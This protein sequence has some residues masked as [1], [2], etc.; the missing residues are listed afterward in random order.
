MSFNFDDMSDRANSYLDTMR[1]QAGEIIAKAQREGEAIRRQAEEEGRQAAIRA[2]EKVMEEKVGKQLATLLPA[3]KQ[4]SEQIIQSKHAWLTHWEKAAVRLA[5]RIAEKVIRRELKQ[6]PTITL[7][8]VREALELAGGDGEL[9]L[10][11]HADD[12]KTLGPHA[13]RLAQEA[14]RGAKVRIVSDIEVMPGGCQV[15]TRFGVV[16]Q[17]IESQLQRIEEEIT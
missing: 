7:T 3:V 13:E 12:V 6:D 2:V 5:A 8:L 4:A 9:V 10:R 17:R 14:S 16:D 11:M 15:E 1:A